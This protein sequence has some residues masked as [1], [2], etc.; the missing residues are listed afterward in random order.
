MRSENIRYGLCSLISNNKYTSIRH[1]N[2]SVVTAAR[3]VARSY[4]VSMLSI[5]GDVEI[6]VTTLPRT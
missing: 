2:C 6:V 3:G 4:D 5:V 1:W